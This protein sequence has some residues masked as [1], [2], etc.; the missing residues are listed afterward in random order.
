MILKKILDFKEADLKN[1]LHS[2]VR[3]CF[4]IFSMVG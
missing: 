2:R 1:D 4:N 3:K